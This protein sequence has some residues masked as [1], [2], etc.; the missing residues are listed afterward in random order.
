MSE[1]QSNFESNLAR[2][3]KNDPHITEPKLWFKQVILAKSLGDGVDS[4][5]VI[6]TFTLKTGLNILWA[7]PEVASTEPELYQDG[8]AGHSTGKT[9]FCRILRHL[10][11]E[12]KFGTKVQRVLEGPDLL[13]TILHKLITKNFLSLH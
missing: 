9:L 1:K 10:L 6:R 12:P 2:E 13:I 8:T 7:E 4:N 3:L 5:N 11:G